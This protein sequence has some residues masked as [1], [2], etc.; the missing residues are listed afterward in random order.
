MRALYSPNSLRPDLAGAGAGACFGL[1]TGAAE[2][3][4]IQVTDARRNFTVNIA[5][6]KH[7]VI[8]CKRAIDWGR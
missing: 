2:Y 7:A 4:L 5:L 6:H 3:K 8:Q 1:G